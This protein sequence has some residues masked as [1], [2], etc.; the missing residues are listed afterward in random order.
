MALESVQAAVGNIGALFV[1]EAWNGY[2]LM[3]IGTK[4]GKR[5]PIHPIGA[6]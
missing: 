2:E 5:A 4:V 6:V 1:Q 3:R